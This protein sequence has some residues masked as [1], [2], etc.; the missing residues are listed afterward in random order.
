MFTFKKTK[1]IY[2]LLALLFLTTSCQQHLSVGNDL[3]VP[4]PQGWKTEQ[5]CEDGPPLCTEWWTLFNDPQLDA[6]EMTALSQNKDLLAACDRILEARALAGIAF[7]DR[8][9]DLFFTPSIRQE[10]ILIDFSDFSPSSGDR[11]VYQNLYA[12]PLDFSY[13]F[14][15]WGKYLHANKAARARLLAAQWGYLNVYNALTS[16]VAILYFSLRTLDEEIGYLE[17]AHEVR[18]LTVHLFRTRVEA[19]LDPEIDLFRAKLELARAEQ[20]LEDTKRLRN[21]GENAL[22]VLLGTFASSFSLE[23]GQLSQENPRIPPDLPSELLLNR[24]DI[25]EKTELVLA[26][27]EEVGVANAE[28]FPSF[29]LTSSLGLVSPQLSHWFTWKDRFWSLTLRS[30]QVLFSGGRLCNQ[31]R[32]AQAC[33]LQAVHDY[34]RQVEIAFQDVENALNEIQYRKKQYEAQKKAQAAAAETTHLAKEQFEAGIINYLQVADAEKMELDAEREAIR[35]KG[36][37]LM[38]AIQLIKALGGGWHAS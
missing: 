19:N 38:A 16:D 24:P 36:T 14:D 34:Q 17:K 27:L 1:G 5:L 2:K 9:P 33:Y 30:L 15:F 21:E 22:A 12:F 18:A 37:N 7:S 31:Q 28:F 25:R 29:S 13:E 11:R 23:R 32:A 4:V 35:L 6:L 10:K 3:A 20:E 26:A 8:L